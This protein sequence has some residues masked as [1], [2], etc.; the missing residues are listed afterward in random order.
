MLTGLLG[1]VPYVVEDLVILRKT[2]RCEV[3]LLLSSTKHKVLVGRTETF[4]APLVS[5]RRILANPFRYRSS[6]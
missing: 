3:Q 1:L 6:R 4:L 5:F 2:V